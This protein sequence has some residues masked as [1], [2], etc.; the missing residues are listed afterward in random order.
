[1]NNKAKKEF[2]LTINKILP[3]DLA[4]PIY[5]HGQDGF[6]YGWTKGVLPLI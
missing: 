6:A 3:D 4:I 1:L 5:Q 2:A